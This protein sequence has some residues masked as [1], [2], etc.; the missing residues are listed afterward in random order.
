NQSLKNLYSEGL[1]DD[2]KKRWQD[3]FPLKE[4]FEKDM[5]K[6]KS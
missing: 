5:D 6:V 2:N 3:A 4:E 1:Y